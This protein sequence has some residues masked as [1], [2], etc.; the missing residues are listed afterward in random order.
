MLRRLPLRRKKP[1]PDSL[2]ARAY[3]KVRA[4]RKAKQPPKVYAPKYAPCVMCDRLEMLDPHHIW[5]RSKRPDLVND[6]RN[7]VYLCRQCHREATENRAAEE[8]IQRWLYPNPPKFR[9]QNDIDITTQ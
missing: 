3:A 1:N 5:R 8:A 6:R 2:A 7:I 9:A 4:D